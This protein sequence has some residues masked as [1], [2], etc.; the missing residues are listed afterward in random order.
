MEGGLV[1]DPKPQTLSLQFWF[2]A[3]CLQGLSSRFADARLRGVQEVDPP[4]QAWS[5]K[6]GG[7]SCGLGF[8][9]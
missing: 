8:K 7:Q 1:G 4:Q 5:Q 9:V 3:S 6:R 2:G